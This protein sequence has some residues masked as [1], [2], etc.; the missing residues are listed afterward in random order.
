MIIGPITGASLNPARAFGPEF[1]SAIGDGTTHWNQL[2]ARSTSCPASSAPA[3]PR[4][5]YDFLADA[6]EDRGADQGS[7]HAT[8]TPRAPT[9]PRPK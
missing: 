5:L 9:S 3:S 7:R 4:S 6:A 8:P 1:V 2:D